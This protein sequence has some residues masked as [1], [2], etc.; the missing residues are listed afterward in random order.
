[1]T[2]VNLPTLPSGKEFEEFL[3]AYF[4]ASGLYVERNVIDRQKEEVLELDF[5]TTQYQ[6]NKPP[7]IKLFEV[8]SGQ[9][10]FGE[11]FKLRGWLDYMHLNSGTL[12]VNKERVPF[13]FY[14]D[15]GQKIDVDLVCIPDL[16]KA[17]TYL[18]GL[19][20]QVEPIDISTWRFSYWTERQLLK[21]LTIKKKSTTDKLAY[22]AMDRYFSMINNRTFFTSNVIHR[23]RKLYEVFQEYPNI[24]SRLGHEL[25]GEDFEKN[26]SDVPRA[27]FE[28]A[29]YQ[30][31]FNDLSIS[32]LIEH[33]SR[34]SILKSAIDYKLY[35]SSG[36]DHDEKEVM[37]FGDLQWET[38]L[39]DLLPQSFKRGLETVSEHKYYFRY[40]VFWQW[41]MWV[42][43]GFILKD[44]EQQEFELMSAKTGIPPGEIPNALSAYS[45]LFPGPEGGWF[46]DQKESNI[47]VLKMFPVPFMGIGANYRKWQ[48]TEDY[49]F[50]KLNLTGMHS[51]GDLL[52]WNRV[53]V[54]LL[55]RHL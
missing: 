43:G 2:T 40:P 32:T 14:Q 38:R 34:L 33:R 54:D 15:I 50:E 20:G 55:G 30:C 46:V 28:E 5:V 12:L 26:H 11:L 7:D 6:E 23:A 16:D 45:M 42:F 29:Y 13:E 24:T 3:A 39:L 27:I 22:G 25:Q 36:N 49:K 31:K 47:R 1:M 44:Y 4:Q 18:E 9:W 41:F 10:G 52:K 35:K 53:V 17:H 51:L 48:Y 21:L 8:K 37:K 19:I